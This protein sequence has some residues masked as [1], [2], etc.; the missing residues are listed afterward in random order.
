MN[1]SLYIGDRSGLV[2][3]AADEAPYTCPTGHTWT[4][5][6]RWR[7]DQAER[8]T[9]FES[10]PSDNNCPECGEDGE[11]RQRRSTAL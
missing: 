3:D 10:I 1:S 6:G 5:S 8:F 7:H 9:Y 11:I 4:V 2:L